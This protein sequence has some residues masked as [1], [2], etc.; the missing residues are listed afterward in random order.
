MEGKLHEAAITGDALELDRLIKED[1]DILSGAAAEETP[2]HIA[3]QLGH[4]EFVA[5]IGILK[6]EF[7]HAK[8]SEG[9]CPLHLASAKGHVETAAKLLEINSDVCFVHDRDG[10]TPLHIAAMKGRIQVLEKLAE[11]KI[12][13]AWVLADCGQPILHLCANHNQFDALKLIIERV[14]DKAPE[15]LVEFVNLKDDDDNTILH[16]LA[17]RAQYQGFTALDVLHQNCGPLD[18]M[19]I[20]YLLGE[21]AK[22]A[23]NIRGSKSYGIKRSM[24]DLLFERKNAEK[25]ETRDTL[26][27]VA[28]LIATVTF[29]AQI[30][31]PGG[32]WQ[33]DGTITRKKFASDQPEEVMYYA[34][35]SVMAFNHP[36]SYSWFITFNIVGF[37]ASLILILLLVSGFTFRRKVSTLA[38]TVTTWIAIMSML[39]IFSVTFSSLKSENTRDVHSTSTWIVSPLWLALIILLAL[40]VLPSGIKY[41]WMHV[42]KG[43][44]RSVKRGFK[45]LFCCLCFRK[46]RE[47]DSEGRND[48]NV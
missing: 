48:V 42:Y 15:K 2:L 6:P 5:M 4:T 3:A 7:A 25:S 8:N 39:V 19:R 32:V 17:A 16:L 11:K 34:G 28:I 18:R 14:K 27:V 47:E 1:P 45:H 46:S 9:Q 23:T 20:K 10:R 44:I 35:Q 22:R 31:P 37:V 24:W 29:Q 26:M 41:I 36:S 43:I 21:R 40:S 38:L 12:K 30:N 33:Q 13:A